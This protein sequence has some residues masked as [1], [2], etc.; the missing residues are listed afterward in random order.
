MIINLRQLAPLKLG[1]E[2]VYVALTRV[3]ESGHVRRLPIVP[4][5][6]RGTGLKSLELADQTKDL[7]KEYDDDGMLRSDQ[8]ALTRRPARQRESGGSDEVSARYQGVERRVPHVSRPASPSQP[9]ARSAISEPPSGSGQP[10]Q[11]E[12]GRRS[13]RLRLRDD[14]D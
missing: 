4:E 3:R 9:S 5:W 8:T 13:L 7:L 1:F 10:R 11:N 14:R 2:A 12:T 6:N